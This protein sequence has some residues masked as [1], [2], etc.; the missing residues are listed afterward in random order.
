MKSAGHPPDF[1]CPTFCF[2]KLFEIV[3]ITNAREVLSGIIEQF[4]GKL[5]A[6]APEV[7]TCF[8]MFH[9]HKD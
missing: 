4:L 1:S 5:N 7:G 8:L 3:Y 2:I 6:L 9:K